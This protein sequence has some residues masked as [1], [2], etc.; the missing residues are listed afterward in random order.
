MKRSEESRTNEA[1]PGKLHEDAVVVVREPFVPNTELIRSSLAKHS[2]LGPTP[3][4]QARRHLG[5]IIERFHTA[6]DAVDYAD[7]ARAG[8]R[9]ALACIDAFLAQHAQ[10]AAKPTSAV[11]ATDAADEEC[12][13]F[14][15]AEAKARNDATDARLRAVLGPCWNHLW[16]P[17][18]ERLGGDYDA[19]KQ[20]LAELESRSE[21]PRAG[22]VEIAAR[23]LCLARS[24][25]DDPQP[26]APRDRWLE[27][28][29]ALNA[30]ARTA[31]EKSPAEGE[32]R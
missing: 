15:A 26:S 11:S 1:R 24:G 32:K 28:I 3:L 13:R 10:R 17:E 31:D 20:R 2:G 16:G 12:E 30:S 4:D 29:D 19:F 21:T 23:R 5:E 18:L 9:D 27:L 7:E 22:A 8:A 25:G 6:E 14:D